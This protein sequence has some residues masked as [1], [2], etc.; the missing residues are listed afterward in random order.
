MST[1]NIILTAIFC[2]LTFILMYVRWIYLRVEYP[3]D[4]KFDR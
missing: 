4:R 2:E 3:E 1:T